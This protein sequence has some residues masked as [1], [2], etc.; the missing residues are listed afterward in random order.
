[1]LAF[2]QTSSYLRYHDKETPPLAT[3]AILG[4]AKG[5]P[6]RGWTKLEH[7]LDARFVPCSQGS[8]TPTREFARIGAWHVTRIDVLLC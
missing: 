6:T 1:M 5:E 3:G 4:P 7:W 8:V 2:P